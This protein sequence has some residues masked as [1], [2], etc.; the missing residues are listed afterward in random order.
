MKITRDDQRPAPAPTEQQHRRALAFLEAAQRQ[1]SAPS[2]DGGELSSP[3][4]LPNFGAGQLDKREIAAQGGR[5]SQRRA[6]RNGQP[7]Y[8]QTKGQAR[9]TMIDRLVA[10]TRRSGVEYSSILFFD[11]NQ[12][13]QGLYAYSYTAIKRGHPNRVEIS[14]S[15]PNGARALEHYHTHNVSSV[16]SGRGEVGRDRGLAGSSITAYV[17]GLDGARRIIRT[18]GYF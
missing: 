14:G 13:G 6:A 9:Q 15:M 12:A 8:H 16:P 5:G 3:V 11:R 17:V 7:R 18:T 2:T 4:R 10:A 1:K